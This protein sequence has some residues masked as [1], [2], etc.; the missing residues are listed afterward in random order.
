M[1]G[2][3]LDVTTER[4]RLAAPF[5]I[6]GHVF[7]HCDV[8]VATLDDG[9]HSGRGEAAGV[10]YLG[11]DV[12]HMTAAIER[13]RAG[14][15]AGI[16]RRGLQQLLPPGGA[17]NA[18]DCALWELEAAQ[19]GQPA[20]KLA[21]VGAPRALTTTFTLGADDPET[22]AAGARGYADARAIKVK[23]TG[24]LALDLDR[25]R[26]IRAARPD[27][28]LGVDA[29][30]GFARADL[31]ALVAGLVEQG[32]SLL[33]Q[34][35]ARG[36]EADLEG[37]RSPIPIA[38]DESALSLADVPGLAGRFDVVNIKLDKC[39]GL[40]EALDMAARA[41][42]LGLGV[43]VGNMVGT[44]LAM[45]PAFVLGQFCDIV[46]LDGPTF[47][48]QDRAPGLVY[49]DGLVDCPP[50]VWGAPGRAAA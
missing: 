18:I 2:L 42:S 28:W 5:R 15:E 14:I 9:T 48:A 30:Q 41:R 3:K 21:G 19:S 50:D 1:R 6:S 33:E 24:E 34:P 43:M 26:A 17:R 44:S 49:R 32:V 29:N 23:L 25:V 35:L 8:I 37:Y 7:E 46:D 20:W 11:D 40:T 39:G 36:A 12:A 13:V 38:A 16:E 22:M 31:D 10:Y 27:V 45:A 47:I 4:L